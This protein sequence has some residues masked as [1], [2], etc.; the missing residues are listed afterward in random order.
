MARAG[1][2]IQTACLFIYFIFFKCQKT[3][4]SRWLLGR[5]GGGGERVLCP[6]S[7]IKHLKVSLLACLLVLSKDTRC[8]SLPLRGPRLKNLR[9]P[10]Q[11][12]KPALCDVQ[13]L[14]TTP[15]TRFWPRPLRPPRFSGLP[16]VEGAERH[17]EAANRGL[18]RSIF[19]GD[20]RTLLK[21]GD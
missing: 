14:V 1:L 5:E 8:P 7:L 12:R 18:K 3:G 20:L 10:T 4:I 16:N 2:A 6:S 19:F 21:I 17:Q 11:V 9:D 13:R 15:T